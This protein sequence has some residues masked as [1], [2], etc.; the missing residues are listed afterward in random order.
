MRVELGEREVQFD[1]LRGNEDFI[2][3]IDALAGR[4][5]M[6]RLLIELLRAFH[7]DSVY[8]NGLNG[9]YPGDLARAY[10]GKRRRSERDAAS[11]L[12]TNLGRLYR[13]Y[14]GRENLLRGFVVE[15]V[16]RHALRGRYGAAG[17][18][19]EDNVKFSLI[20]GARYDSTRTIDVIG[21]ERARGLGEV[22][23]CKT[24]A[25]QWKKAS[26]AAWVR[27]LETEAV[28]R[29]VRVGLVTITGRD[30]AQREL[31][32]AGVGARSRLIALESIWDMAPLQAA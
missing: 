20:N 8:R 28:S 4:P 27:E 25:S 22:H 29:G 9:R 30:R 14:A 19:L 12:V 13:V 6:L 24:Q 26:A 15:T 23:D 7:S 21:F 32:A 16:V 5:F 3:L 31:A 2:A 1:D 11:R 10:V 18:V 17:D